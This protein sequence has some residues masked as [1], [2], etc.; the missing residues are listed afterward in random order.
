LKNI[1]PPVFPETKIC[2]FGNNHEKAVVVIRVQESDETPHTV[3]RTTGI[4]VRV[5]SQ[6][7]PQR[8]RYEEIEWLI[9][10]REKAVENRERL[11]R[12]AEE[13]FDNQPRRKNLIFR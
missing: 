11:L 1:Y 13:R 12:R 5:E 2:R 9:N 10:R 7:E 3:E 6:N 8:A 4:Y